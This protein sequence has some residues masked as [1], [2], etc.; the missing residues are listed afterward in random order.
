MS[1]NPGSSK[2]RGRESSQAT[3]RPESIPSSRQTTPPTPM[4]TLAVSPLVTAGNG[5]GLGAFASQ[6]IKA[7]EVIIEEKPLLTADVTLWSDDTSPRSI[8][9]AF[10]D[11][12]PDRQEY[13]LNR[14]TYVADERKLLDYATA[15]T[16]AANVELPTKQEKLKIGKVFAIFYNTAASFGNFDSG[17]GKDLPRLNHS[18]VPNAAHIFDETRKRSVVRAIRDIPAGQ[19]ILLSYVPEIA[20]KNVRALK[21]EPYGFTCTCLACGENDYANRTEARRKELWKLQSQIDTLEFSE[22][23]EHEEAVVDTEAPSLEDIPDMLALMVKLMKGEPAMQVARGETAYK[24]GKQ[25]SQ[26]QELALAKKWLEFALPLLTLCRGENDSLTK[27]C[28]RMLGKLP[29][30]RHGL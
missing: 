20:P 22:G 3:S 9:D 16:A 29:A 10:A 6:R 17:F 25:C 4:L 28:V 5:Q 12:W 7:G 18:C 15:Y 13:Y 21:L 1:G 24:L 23:S 19:E 8:V 11:M 14:Y 26:M 30:S 27:D 2:D